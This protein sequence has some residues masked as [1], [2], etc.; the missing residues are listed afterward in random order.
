MSSPRFSHSPLTP[1]TLIRTY[2]IPE[3]LLRSLVLAPQPPLKLGIH[4]GVHVDLGRGLSPGILSCR[5]R[6]RCCR[7]SHRSVMKTHLAPSTERVLAR[8]PSAQNC[9][10]HLVHLMLHRQACRKRW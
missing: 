6:G 8:A 7:V 4:I 10:A 1:L 9:P 2:Y 3:T 5:R